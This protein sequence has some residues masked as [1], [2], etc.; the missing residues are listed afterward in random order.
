M[1]KG[2]LECYVYNEGFVVLTFVKKYM[3]IDAIMTANKGTP[4]YYTLVPINSPPPPPNV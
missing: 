3:M 4:P 1:R 2:M